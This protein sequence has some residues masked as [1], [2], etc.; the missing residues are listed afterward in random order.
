MS[1]NQLPNGWTDRQ[2]QALDTLIDLNDAYQVAK[3]VKALLNDTTPEATQVMTDL[4]NLA[5]DNWAIVKT[6]GS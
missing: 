5:R 3:T 2:L 4:A 6:Y 1:L